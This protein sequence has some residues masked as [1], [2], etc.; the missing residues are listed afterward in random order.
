MAQTAWGTALGAQALVGSRR[1]T[2]N[3]QFVE[4]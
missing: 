3:R 1:E 2:L 4:A